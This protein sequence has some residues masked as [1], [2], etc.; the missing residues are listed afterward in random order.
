MKSTIE[1]DAF[2]TELL[3]EALFELQDDLKSRAKSITNFADEDDIVALGKKFYR[4]RSIRLRL[5]DID[6]NLKTEFAA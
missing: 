1:L 2:E 6:L 4:A 3:I 5:A